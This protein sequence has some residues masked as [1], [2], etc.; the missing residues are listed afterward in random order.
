MLAGLSANGVFFLPACFYC[1]EIPKLI[2]LSLTWYSSCY[3]DMS[4][5]DLD[6][7]CPIVAAWSRLEVVVAKVAS[8]GK[9]VDSVGKLTR[10]TCVDNADIL[11]PLINE[12]GGL[13]A[14]RCVKSLKGLLITHSL[15]CKLYRLQPRCATIHRWHC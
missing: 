4:S 8:H 15:I 11:I 10:Q 7:Q 9:M 6:A 12:F 5:E 2:G 14:I 1:F 13:T 3:G